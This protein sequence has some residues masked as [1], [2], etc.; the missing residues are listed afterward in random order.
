MH[1]A[2]KGNCVF[3]NEMIKSLLCV[4]LSF[5]SHLVMANG[6]GNTFE[7]QMGKSVV[8]CNRYMFEHEIATDVI[9]EVGPPDGTVGIVR[10]HKYMLI[11]RSAVFEAMFCGGLAESHAAQGTKIPITDVDVG[12][13]QEMLRLFSEQFIFV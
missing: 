4:N 13:F 5:C 2:L 3:A 1:T 9:F 11:A 8:E 7:W 12:I 10:A 6:R